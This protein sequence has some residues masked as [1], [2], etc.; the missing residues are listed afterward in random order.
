MAFRLLRMIGQGGAALAAV[1]IATAPLAARPL[2]DE[3]AP[4][5]ADADDDALCFVSGAYIGMLLQ[6]RAD[7]MK[8]EQRERMELLRFA[9]PFYAA[10]LN[11]RFDDDAALEDMLT[12]ARKAFEATDDRDKVAVDCYHAYKAAMTRVAGALSDNVAGADSP[13]DDTE[14][15][16]GR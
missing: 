9:L 6:A 15:P 3:D 2:P 14:A 8:R 4:A 1:G 7:D 11:A 16:Q 5:V 12:T 10:R 13:A